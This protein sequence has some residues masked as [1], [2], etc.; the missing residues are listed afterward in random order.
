MTER[1]IKV[2][3]IAG[4]IAFI[5]S[6]VMLDMNGYIKH[7][8]EDSAMLVDEFRLIRIEPGK[9]LKISP[10]TANKEAFCVDGFLLIRPQKNKSGKEV[11]G[12]LIDEKDRGIH[13]SITLPA[14]VS[15]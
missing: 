12:I 4:V 6:V 8:S 3:I 13:C 15:Q 1:D 5:T 9:E 7:S 14:P 2:A 11:A 10:K